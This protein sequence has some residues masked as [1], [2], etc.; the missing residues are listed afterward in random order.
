MKPILI[1]AVLLAGTF[2]KS[3]ANDG[4][5]INPAILKS[6]KSTFASATEVGWSTTAQ[7]LYKAVFLMNGQYITAYYNGDGSMQAVSRHISA[8]SLP[9]TLQT[10][11]KNNYE[12]QWVSD[13]L[14]VTN[15][16]SLQYYVTLENADSKVVLKSSSNTWTSYQKQRK[17]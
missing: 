17:D 1:A 5:T 3:F 10:E 7:E 12:N 4:I 16:G 6:F 2:T 9:L 13:V 11:L 8:G 15:D 14:E